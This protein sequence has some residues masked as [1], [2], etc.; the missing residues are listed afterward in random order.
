LGDEKHVDVFL[1]QCSALKNAR[2]LGFKTMFKTIFP[3]SGSP[4]LVK[5]DV[6]FMLEMTNIILKNVKSDPYTDYISGL[7][8]HPCH[9][10]QG[11]VCPNH[12][13]PKWEWRNFPSNFGVNPLSPPISS[14]RIILSL[15]G[16]Q[17]PLLINDNHRIIIC[18]GIH[19]DHYSYENLDKTNETFASTSSKPIFGCPR[20]A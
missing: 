11:N 15:L 12:P 2:P 13:F 19:N 8:G 4:I 9:R 7:L 10:G 18:T 5:K 16:V 1:N 3:N 20:C 17:K 6:S 14:L